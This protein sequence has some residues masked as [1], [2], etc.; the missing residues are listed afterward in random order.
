[1]HRAQFGVPFVQTVIPTSGKQIDSL[2]FATDPFV[3]ELE[4]SASRRGRSGAE[5]V[6]VVAGLAGELHRLDLPFTAL[7]IPLEIR[8][9]MLERVIELARATTV[10]IEELLDRGNAGIEVVRRPVGPEFFLLLRR[11]RNRRYCPVDRNDRVSLESPAHVVVVRDYALS[12]AHRFV[13]EL[14]HT[15]TYGSGLKDLVRF[16]FEE[17]GEAWTANETGLSYAHQQRDLAAINVTIDL[18]HRR[19][20][21]AAATTES[22]RMPDDD[23]VHAAP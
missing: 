20:S 13:A 7:H 23:S 8:Q 12:N 19:A 17:I 18:P 16:A 1:M 14:S 3:I 2:H 4:K 6:K 11:W 9:W 15:R 10:L 22:I 21:D 5:E